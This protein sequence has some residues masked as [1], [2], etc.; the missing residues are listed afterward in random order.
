M[1]IGMRIPSPTKSVKARTTGRLKRA[2]KKSYNPVYGM[3]GIGYLKDP[4]RAVKNKIYHKLT[5][6][7]LDELK[8]PGEMKDF[9]I[10]PPKAKGSP[11]VGALCVIFIIALIYTFYKFVF[12]QELHLVPLAITLISFVIIEVVKWQRKRK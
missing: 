10:E 9:Q 8:N 11:I 7:P 2:A 6:D 5:Y 4:E 12:R 1:K 3:K